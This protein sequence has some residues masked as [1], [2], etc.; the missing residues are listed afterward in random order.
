MTFFL[1]LLT[2]L[3]LGAGALVVAIF[4]FSRR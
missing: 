1:E 2:W 3:A 4:L